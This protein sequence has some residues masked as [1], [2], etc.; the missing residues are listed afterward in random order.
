MSQLPELQLHNSIHFGNRSGQVVGFVVVEAYKRD[1][2]AETMAI[3]ELH[4]ES[5]AYLEGREHDCFVTKMLVNMDNFVI[6]ED[7]GY[8]Y[9]RNENR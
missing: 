4:K 6:N 2:P 5:A 3:V 8:Y 7:D 9:E 1:D